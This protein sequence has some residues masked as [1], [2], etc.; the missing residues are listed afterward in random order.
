MRPV[1]DEEALTR[2]VLQ[3]KHLKE[4]QRFRAFLPNSDGQ[5]SIFRTTGWDEARI[6]NTGN[7]FVAVPSN[8]TVYGRADITA[9]KVLDQGL[10]I[11]PSEPPRDHAD[12]LG[13]PDTTD[14][15][16]K[17]QARTI[18]LQLVAHATFKAR[19]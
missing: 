13:W 14:D 12:I 8:N 7:E 5:V 17:A 16:G 6:W 18:A 9:R 4:G 11:N 15:V 3:Q 1:A 10:T 19:P 2:Y